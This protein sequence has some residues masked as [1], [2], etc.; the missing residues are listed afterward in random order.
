VLLG[1]GSRD[2]W[3]T[4]EKLEADVARLRAAGSDVTVLVTDA[5]HE[6]TAEFSRAA[7]EFLRRAG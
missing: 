1:R 5:A 3:Y 2:G 7:G 4:R 6:W